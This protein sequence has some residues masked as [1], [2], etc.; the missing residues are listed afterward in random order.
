MS[1]QLSPASASRFHRP[2]GSPGNDPWPVFRLDQ[3]DI[4]GKYIKIMLNWFCLTCWTRVSS[5]NKNTVL[6][7]F[8]CFADCMLLIDLFYTK[9]RNTDANLPWILDGSFH[10]ATSNSFSIVNF[11]QYSQNHL[12]IKHGKLEKPP[13][14][15]WTTSNQ[16][17]VCHLHDYQRVPKNHLFPG[18]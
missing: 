10:A 15:R 13:S 17:W 8:V 18:P 12:R 5:W 16:C 9:T 3:K 7:P 14:F 11:W 6:L 1:W 2:P 4:H